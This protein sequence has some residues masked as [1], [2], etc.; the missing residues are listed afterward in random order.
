MRRPAQRPG[1]L[2]NLPRVSLGDGRLTFL[3][4]T[5]EP[6]KPSPGAWLGLEKVKRSLALIRNILP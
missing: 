4:L 2:E 3:R 1:L 6:L 5:A